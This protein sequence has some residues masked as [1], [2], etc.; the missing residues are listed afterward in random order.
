MCKDVALTKRNH[1]FLAAEQDVNVTAEQKISAVLLY[2]QK[3]PK[4]HGVVWVGTDLREF[5]DNISTLAQLSLQK[6]GFP[7]SNKL[8]EAV[9]N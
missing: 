4:N 1:P 9:Y 3:I 7:E 5:I 6:D 8:L 2:W